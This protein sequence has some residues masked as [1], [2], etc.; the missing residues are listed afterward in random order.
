MRYAVWAILPTVGAIA[1]AGW[2]FLPRPTEAQTASE[3]MH[4]RLDYAQAAYGDKADN[5]QIANWGRDYS[6]LNPVEFQQKH[7]REPYGLMIASGVACR[8][9]KD[10]DWSSA[11]HEAAVDADASDWLAK[12]GS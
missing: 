3:L 4:C 12:A 11:A 9:K 2:M 5:T 6:L 7:G 10:W 1:V 8:G